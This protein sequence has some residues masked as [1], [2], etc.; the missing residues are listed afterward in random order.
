MRTMRR[1]RKR[2]SR[3]SLSQ[4]DI[5]D[6]KSVSV[7]DFQESDEE[8]AKTAEKSKQ[9]GSS[10]DTV[11]EEVVK[12]NYEDPSVSGPSP[13]IITMRQIPTRGQPLVRGRGGK[14]PVL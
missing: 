11:I 3:A 7:F 13:T 12:G 10:V 5:D 4:S 9:S 1:R 6:R 2:R 8:S 14:A